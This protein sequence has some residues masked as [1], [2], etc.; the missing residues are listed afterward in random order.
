[1]A[2]L[3]KCYHRIRNSTNVHRGQKVS[4]GSVQ[5]RQGKSEHHNPLRN[6]GCTLVY[7]VLIIMSPLHLIHRVKILNIL[8]QF[9]EKSS[10]TTLIILLFFSSLPPQINYKFL[11]IQWSKLYTCLRRRCIM[12][13]ICTRQ[14]SCGSRYLS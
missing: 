7:E 4:N 3:P 10:T 5:T 6:A 13:W 9:L 2:E 14:C 8:Y 12:I 11:K 1:M